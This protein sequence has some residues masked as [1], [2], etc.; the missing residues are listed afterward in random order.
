MQNKWL[1]NIFQSKL[2]DPNLKLS[3]AEVDT[4]VITDTQVLIGWSFE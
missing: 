3:S 4:P 2:I 1:K